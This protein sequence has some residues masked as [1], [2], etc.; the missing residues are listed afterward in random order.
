[1]EDLRDP[2]GR[3]G[4]IKGGTDLA[5]RNVLIFRCGDEAKLV[6]RPS[7]TEPKAKTYIEVCTPP[8]RPGVPE[9]T[10]QA[11]C[12]AADALLARLSDDFLRQVLGLIGLDPSAVG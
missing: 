6:L 9:E 11:K 8:A 10:W 5:S 4:P 7:G 1:M 12:R 2:E 3:F